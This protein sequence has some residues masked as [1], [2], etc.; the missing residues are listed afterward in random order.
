MKV[1]VALTGASGNMG[2]ATLKEL[3]ESPVVGQ[4][5]ILLLPGV[6]EGRF[7]AAV[8]K[9]YG[10]KVVVLRGNLSDQTA[11]RTLLE[12]VDYLLHLAAVIPPLSDHKPKL[13]MEC[14]LIGTRNLIAVLQDKPNVGFVHISSVAVYGHRNYRHPW[15]RVGD[16]LLPSVYD[17]Y[18]Q[19]KMFA[20]RDVM[21]SGLPKWAVLRQTAMLHNRMLSDNMRDGLM[22][23]TVLNVPLEWVTAEDSGY[24]MR[25][26]VEK[27]L[28]GEAE[29]FWRQCYNIGG[30]AANRYTGYDTFDEGF[31][32]IGG[33]AERFI[34]PKWCSIRN[35]H[36]LWFA[37]SD[38]LNRLFGYQRQ[39]VSDFW[40]QIAKSHPYFRLARILPPGII[41]KLA[42]E[43][44]LKDENAPDRWVRQGLEGKVKAFFGSRENLNCIEGGW[45]RYPVLCKGQIADGDIDYE[46]LR[47]DDG[48]RERGLLLPHGFDD[49]KPL[50]DITAEDLR[51]AAAWRGG[52]CLIE[53]EGTVDLYSPVEWRCA[54][55]HTFRM[56][57]YAVLYGGHWCSV[58]Y[59]QGVW[60]FDL[61][62][63]RNPYFAAVWYD[64][65][66]RNENVRY[67]IQAGRACYTYGG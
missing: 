14:N 35:F 33:S 28:A 51:S 2:R 55:G 20:E 3:A 45:E 27:D 44:L 38:R 13:A 17:V 29:G 58:C 54:E 7:A 30:G 23:H 41:R 18:A 4:I 24:L 1:N 40:Q 56:T 8:T 9:Q 39:S 67:F 60:D 10:E 22:F 36:G 25:R 52:Q 47:K 15:G 12:G 26:I 19:T 59:R 21:E 37:D 6:K 32:M 63:K 61:L 57:P 31:R 46:E 34:R 49:T 43:R 48:L 64:S 50:A 62:A 66:A 42:I 11:C 16:P 65:H 53:G 5:R